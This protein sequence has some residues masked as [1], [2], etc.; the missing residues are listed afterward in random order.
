MKKL[1][2]CCLCLLLAQPV[3][4]EPETSSG[5]K[6]GVGSGMAQAA[7]ERLPDSG[8]AAR[9]EPQPFETIVRTVEKNI[10][11]LPDCNDKKLLAEA[12]AFVT[13]YY[14]KYDNKGVMFRRRRHFILNALQNLNTENVANYKTQDARPVSDIIAELKVN[15]GV[16]EENMLLCKKQ[17]SIKGVKDIYL[18]VYPSDGGYKVHVL[19]LD[20]KRA[21]GYENVFEYAK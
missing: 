14:Q 12:K 13:A 20:P 17:M 2:F 19:N 18:L 9:E 16:L 11:P 1:F 21:D 5:E 3:W 15:Q 6:A 4:A 7:E 10:I 8:H